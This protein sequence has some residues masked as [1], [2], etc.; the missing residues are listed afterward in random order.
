MRLASRPR[1][2]AAGD[3]ASV[4]EDETLS[5][6]HPLAPATASVSARTMDR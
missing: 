5:A 3:E 4:R 1:V 2:G 6:E